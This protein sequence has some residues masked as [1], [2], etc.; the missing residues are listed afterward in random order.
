[1]ANSRYP[2][3]AAILFFSSSALSVE[4]VPRSVKPLPRTVAPIAVKPAPMRLLSPNGGERIAI[5]SGYRVRWGGRDTSGKISLQL[6]A[7]G[8]P[9]G[10][11]AR[12]L[13]ASTGSYNWRV[14]SVLGKRLKAGANYRIA[15]K[16]E[17]GRTLD[18]SDR[19][20]S[21]V[22]EAKP[23]AG[24][25]PG[26]KEL[27]PAEI[28]RMR[29]EQRPSR[30]AERMKAP[31]MVGIGSRHESGEPISITS[32]QANEGW[33]TDAS[34]TITWTSTLP[35][36]TDVKIEL[37]RSHVDGDTVWQTVTNSTAN[38]GSFEWAGIAASNYNQSSK[39]FSVRISTLDDAVVAKSGVVTFGKP[40]YFH[41]PAAAYTWRKGS[42]KSIQ[43]EKVCTLPSPVSID[44]L[45]S[46]GQQVANIAS[47]ISPTPRASTNKKEI[48][49]WNVP[50]NLYSGSYLLRVSSGALAVEQAIN[51]DDPIVFPSS[52]DIT[53]TE[54]TKFGGWCTDSPHTIRWNTT[55]P[56][57]TS[58]NIDLTG[59]DSSG[60][61]L[62]RTLVDNTP[63]DGVYEWAGIASADYNSVSRGVRVRIS[64][65]DNSAVTMGDIFTFGKPL[66]FI[67]PSAPY[68]WRRGTS[69][70]LVW[71]IVCTLPNA[72]SVDLLDD[73]GQHVLSI[74]SGLSPVPRLSTNKKVLHNWAIPSSLAPG[75]YTI[76][77]SSGQIVLDKG[78]NITE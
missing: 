37:V 63:N 58:V 12:G 5:G 39:G 8:K 16:N 1:M 52:P 77:I 48:Q 76:R 72:I 49:Q 40:L 20:F 59:T 50:G 4:V 25:R 75:S 71:E 62:W 68:S 44:L 31:A 61:T 14:G 21:L 56:A 65:T 42:Q 53:I 36:S 41:Q 23:G 6:L 60:I 66:Y 2:L 13:K 57:T 32:P 17:K 70:T 64:T 18:Q 54:P 19:N 28:S 3:L 78:I 22:S 15:L 29:Q 73:N 43:W 33:C 38:D 69:R 34:H 10:N 67:E 51:I 11:L 7:N 46:Q 27:K 35:A 55:L 30:G 26:D 24:F 74:A 47:G 45:D 9:V